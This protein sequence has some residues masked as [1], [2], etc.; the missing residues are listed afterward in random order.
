MNNVL[1]RRFNNFSSKVYLCLGSQLF[2][3][4]RLVLDNN[5]K[6]IVFSET[7][8]GM[9]FLGM[10]ITYY[11]SYISVITSQ[12][13]FIKMT[14]LG[15]FSICESIIVTNWT[16]NFSYESILTILL[17]TGTIFSTLSLF[18]MYQRE[19]YSVYKG[20]AFNIINSLLLISILGFIF[21][22][23]L[24]NVIFS[25]LTIVLISLYVIMDTQYL[26]LTDSY[27]FAND[28]YTMVSL[29]LYTDFVLLFIRILKLFGRG[30]FK[31][32]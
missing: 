30:K 4:F 18:S 24:L 8:M 32:F 25:V 7:T 13:N 10:L 23:N 16:K 17:T 14:L 29:K 6:N 3:T 11:L 27:Y 26:L 28:A 2:L 15:I 9:S 19:N 31:L 5:R 21:Y 1:M 20:I 22:S 12:S